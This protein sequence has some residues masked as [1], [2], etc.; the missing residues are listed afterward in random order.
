MI[1]LVSI[2]SIILAGVVWTLSTP[3]LSRDVLQSRYGLSQQNVLML[4]D[5]SVAYKDTG[6]REAPAVLLL[7]GFGSSLQT[8]DVWSQTL[9]LN[10]R[11]IRLDL[12]GFGLT[13]P[14]ANNDYSE[15]Q[16]LK[17][18]IQF[19][20]KLGVNKLAVVGHSMGGKLAWSFAAQQPNRVTA[21]VLMA[22]DG[23]PKP[24]DIGTR[25]YASPAIM[26]IMKY[27]LP[28]YVVQKSIEP[29]FS[30]VGA[31]TPTLLNRYHDMLR[32]PGVRAAIL[33]RGNQT[34][35][36]D[37][38]P[39]LKA[40]TSPTLLIWG[41]E[42]H[43]I[44]SSNARNYEGVMA[45]AKVWVLPH[46]GHLIQEEQPQRGLAAVIDFLREPL[47]PMSLRQGVK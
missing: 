36:T 13:G 14:S 9:E 41:A 20:D 8:W 6:P 34:V 10:Y 26:G 18:L 33:A 24:E 15:A 16:D 38:V 19:L 31:L 27:V 43:M 45:Q 29:A 21:L 37:P 3:D 5:I 39:R 12:P 17:S 44:S 22:P 7:H 4:D 28:K 23:F 47:A 40:I 25:P 30:D 35:Y 46:V 32:A 11:V 1:K 42:D 2:M